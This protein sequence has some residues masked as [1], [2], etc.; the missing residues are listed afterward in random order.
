MCSLLKKTPFPHAA[1]STPLSSFLSD[2]TLDSLSFRPL[3]GATLASSLGSPNWTSVELHC[4]VGG[5]SNQRRLVCGKKM[6]SL[7][8]TLLGWLRWPRNQRL[9]VN[10]PNQGIKRSL[11]SPRP[12]P[13]DENELLTEQSRAQCSGHLLCIT[14]RKEN[15][16]EDQHEHGTYKSPMKRKENDLNQT[17]M[18]MCHVNLQGWN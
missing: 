8:V 10:T 4:L 15:T 11:G 14:I 2:L 13:S 16:P 12:H 5:S 17:S 9:L 3:G 6:A 18:I 7:L 1:G